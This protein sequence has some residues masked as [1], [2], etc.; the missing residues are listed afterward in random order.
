MRT[1]DD[2]LETPFKVRFLTDDAEDPIS[3]PSISSTSQYSMRETIGVAD[4]N[5]D[6]EAEGQGHGFNGDGE[7]AACVLSKRPGDLIDCLKCIQDSLHSVLSQLQRGG[8]AH[9][10]E[11]LDSLYRKVNL[12]GSNGVVAEAVK[13]CPLNLGC[14]CPD[15]FP[16]N[17]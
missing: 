16:R 10:A 13:V 17:Y 12:A 6:V 15:S 2:I 8:H 3:S 5:I 1:D 4:I 14:L 11:L 7:T 9:D